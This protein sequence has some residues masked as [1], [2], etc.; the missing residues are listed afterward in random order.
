MSDDTREGLQI[1]RKRD[2]T[3]SVDYTEDLDSLTHL[4]IEH[5]IYPERM[6]THTWPEIVARAPQ[7][8]HCREHFKRCIERVEQLIGGA[9]IAGADVLVDLSEV[10]ARP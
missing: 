10:A 8:R 4:A 2:V 1:E 9:T 7:L 5:E 3:P 6:A